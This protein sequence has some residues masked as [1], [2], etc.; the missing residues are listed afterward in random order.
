[1]T[2]N[3]IEG[4]ALAALGL[5]AQPAPAAESPPFSETIVVTGNREAE[6]AM[7]FETRH[8]LDTARIDRIGA[9]SADSL[10]QRLPGVH[11][12]ANSRGEAIAFLRNAAER[13]V[14]IFYEGADI[15]IPWDNRLDLSLVPAALIGGVRSASG[16]L[17]PHYG[18][19]ALG[20]ISLS[21]RSALHARVEAGSAG[22]FAGEAAIPL[23]PLLVGGSY[24]QRDGETLSRNAVLPFGQ[25]GRS[26]RTNT[27]R[28]LASLFGRVAGEAGAHDL[29]FTAFRVW[30]EKGIA[31]EGNRASGARFWRYPDIR[32][33]LVAARVRSRIGQSTELD[34]AAWLQ[35]FGQTIDSYASAAYQRVNSRQ[36]DRDRTWGLRELLKHSVGSATLVGSFNYLESSHRQRDIAFNAGA[37]PAALPPALVYGQRNWSV[38]AELEYEFMPALRAELGIGHDKVDYVRTGD[39]PS[40]KDAE[41]WTGRA[42]VVF[43]AGGGYR[44]RG[45]IGRKMRAPTLRERFGEAIQRFLPNPALRPERIRSAEIA[46]ERRFEAGR[47]YVIP[48]VQDLRDTIDQ[49]NVGS[50]RQRI[51]LA[52]SSVSGVEAGG[53]WRPVMGLALTEKPALLARAALDYSHGSGFSTG[54]EAEHVGRAF[55]ADSAGLLVP[56]ARSTVLNWRVGYEI[57]RKDFG[58]ELFFHVDN[59]G[60]SLVEPQLGLPA[61]GRTLRFGIR[62]G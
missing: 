20:A 50:L 12:P 36:V 48:F 26:L 16:P 4:A 34:S 54:L 39:K 8:N 61:A 30:G 59:L 10:L 19:N 2:R 18:V 52:G 22:L 42:A 37:L 32:H 41:G 35:W 27:D 53:D 38:G 33:S 21:P 15:N 44:L 24:S 17:A 51:N 60:D 49:R 29:S 5:L 55:S 13:Q 3:G 28:E 31:S 47:L 11:V 25:T 6:D 56:L 45:A 46:I 1:M 43:D 23:G 57:R 14:A 58:I 40:V 9:A 7:S 62:L